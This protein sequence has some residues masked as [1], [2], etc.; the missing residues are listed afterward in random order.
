MDLSEAH[1]LVLFR[2]IR[3]GIGI[4]QRLS[5]IDT[6]APTGVRDAHPRTRASPEPT[7]HHQTKI[8]G[9]GK[10]SSPETLKRLAILVSQRRNFL[11]SS[12]GLA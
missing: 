1:G 10:G 5:V 7:G 3:E 11:P 6:C 4:T 9:D 2:V 8:T 12:K